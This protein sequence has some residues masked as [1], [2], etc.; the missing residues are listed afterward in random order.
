M[1]LLLPLRWLLLLALALVPPLAR[2][3]SPGGGAWLALPLLLDFQPALLAIDT[4]RPFRAQ[5]ERFCRAHGLDPRHC[6][7]AIMGGAGEVADVGLRCRRADA[8]GKLPGFLMIRDALPAADSHQHTRGGALAIWLRDE[9]A[10]IAYDLCSFVRQ[11]GDAGAV[12]E[13]C[14]A[15]LSGS[16]EQSFQWLLSL[17]PCD[18]VLGDGKSG[19]IKVVE[20]DTLSLQP[21]PATR[22]EVDAPSA[23]LEARSED[24][25][26]PSG[27][28]LQ[29]DMETAKLHLSFG[30]AHSAK[31]TTKQAGPNAASNELRRSDIPNVKQVSLSLLQNE[32]SH[33][34]ST[35]A[36][37]PAKIHN[38]RDI[39]EELQSRENP[40]MV[41]MSDHSKTLQWVV[42]LVLS[43]VLAIIYLLFDLAASGTHQDQESIQAK[44]AS[45]S[46]MPFRVMNNRVTTTTKTGIAAQSTEKDRCHEDDG[47]EAILASDTAHGNAEHNFGPTKQSGSQIN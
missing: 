37:M 42:A 9:P 11:E 34:G 40:R 1:S 39:H 30:T 13:E 21:T 46:S 14:A 35:N 18:A 12:D 16:L 6:G 33:C 26:H 10:H 15:A 5:V 38:P 28:K 17:D 32:S 25:N 3:H 29:T 2:A 20:R 45:S 7:H 41:E 43:L 27:H 31:F 47:I 8:A 24:A 19:S 22:M 36:A 23:I 4:R 44:K